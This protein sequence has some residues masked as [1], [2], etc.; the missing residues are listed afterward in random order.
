MDISN[1]M[2]TTKT[3]PGL[4]FRVLSV[5]VAAE[6]LKRH[7]GVLHECLVADV[8]Q[9][10]PW[11]LKA[12][13]KELD[14]RL[15]TFEAPFNRLE[16]I[17]ESVPERL[18][19]LES[20]VN[21]RM[22]VKVPGMEEEVFSLEDLL[23][24]SYYCHIEQHSMFMN[25]PDVARTWGLPNGKFY[26]LMGQIDQSS[27]LLADLGSLKDFVAERPDSYE[28]F[29]RQ[30]KEGQYVTSEL[31]PAL[32]VEFSELLYAMYYE[33]KTGLYA[34]MDRVCSYLG[35]DNKEVYN[36]LKEQL[37]NHPL[38][39]NGRLTPSRYVANKKESYQKFIERLS[40]QDVYVQIEDDGLK[41]RKV[42]LREMA[43]FFHLAMNGEVTTRNI[44]SL[45]GIKAS[46][47]TELQN[48]VMS[49]PAWKTEGYDALPYS[50]KV[51]EGLKREI[52]EIRKQ[53]RREFPGVVEAKEGEVEAVP[54]IPRKRLDEMSEKELVE[55]VRKHPDVL[56]GVPRKSLTRRIVCEAV[57]ENGF[58]LQHVPRRFLY[59]ELC[60][61]AVQNAGAS[62]QF[63]PTKRREKELCYAAVKQNALAYMHVPLRLRHDER[64]CDIAITQH[65]GGY[66]II[67]VP[68]ELIT[69]AL[70]RRAVVTTSD[71]KAREYYRK[72]QPLSRMSSARERYVTDFNLLMFDRAYPITNDKQLTT[73]E[74]EAFAAR[75]SEV[76]RFYDGD[77]PA[78]ELIGKIPWPKRYNELDP[79]SLHNQVFIDLF[80]M[81]RRTPDLLPTILTVNDQ[82]LSGNLPE[83]IADRYFDEWLK[84]AR[85]EGLMEVQFG[86]L[87]DPSVKE[88]LVALMKQEATLAVAYRDGQL[89]ATDY[90][91][92]PPA[93]CGMP[94]DMTEHEMRETADE[95]SRFW[96]ARLLEDKRLSSGRKI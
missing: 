92:T 4:R 53:Y 20:V 81:V 32:R 80:Q 57:K 62:L 68:E 63:V 13:V 29:R 49:H 31:Q 24:A 17:V 60:L 72:T 79:L 90:L 36:D 50:D 7:P 22:Y 77:V 30:V 23:F 19:R 42:G 85:R 52:A 34:E 14:S 28:R 73:E 39:K 47:W 54:A 11:G 84:S 35:V 48:T 82:Q 88:A 51:V 40:H 86:S 26:A 43:A 33:R 89:S 65:K 9:L 10:Q 74:K 66:N 25:G 27:F 56:A 6:F 55:E 70:V 69:S 2:I 91:S 96:S 75:F 38:F 5:A 71:E 41:L 16:G 61:M 78:R 83:D 67:Y 45:W 21:D 12:L 18:E 37:Q 59:P 46:A 94:Q 93:G 1:E 76:R 87:S 3:L 15:P 44:Q 64:L 8:M 58:A 95:R